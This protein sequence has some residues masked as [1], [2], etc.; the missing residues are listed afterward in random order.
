MGKGLCFFLLLML[1]GPFFP[2]RAA[3]PCGVAVSVTKTEEVSGG[4]KRY[5]FSETDLVN[6]QMRTGSSVLP[7]PKNSAVDF[8]FVCVPRCP[9]LFLQRLHFV[10]P[11]SFCKEYINHIYPSHHFW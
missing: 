7:V 1:T 4:L 11:A 3:K 6:R 2:C 5:P 8:G 9:N 10:F